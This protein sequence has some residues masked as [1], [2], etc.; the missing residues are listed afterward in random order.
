MQ[1][2]H[3]QDTAKQFLKNSLLNNGWTET[4]AYIEKL[5]GLEKLYRYY[6]AN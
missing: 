6:L 5:T 3:I 1:E 4:K 2:L